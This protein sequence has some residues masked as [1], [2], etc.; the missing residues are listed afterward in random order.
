MQSLGFV[1]NITPQLQDIKELMAATLFFNM[2]LVGT[3]S[4]E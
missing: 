3:P 4:T 1:I 2:P